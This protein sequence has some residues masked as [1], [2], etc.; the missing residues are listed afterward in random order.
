M[1]HMDLAGFWALIERS[2]QETTGPIE[3]GDWLAA[4]LTGLADE[5][6]IDFQD[7]LDAQTDRVG[8]WLMWHAASLIQGGCSD[9]GFSGFRA[10]LVGLG[11]VVFDR[12]A[13]DPDRLADQPEVQRLAGRHSRTW[14]EEEWP[15][16][17]ELEFVAVHEY[18]RRYGDCASIY[19]AQTSRLTTA[20]PLPQPV[21]EERWDHYDLAES[22]QRLPRLAAMFPQAG[23]SRAT[24]EAAQ[25]SLM[26][27]KEGLE[28]Q[29]AESGRT[30]AE[31]FRGIPP[32]T[33]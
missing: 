23:P 14:A 12:V 27:A 7:H 32:R 13:D 11:P 8:S 9:D 4:A 3:R 5:D 22:R 31:F 20:E 15:Y 21:E 2:A 18:E 29:L 17:E 28:R 33:P 24:P 16:R 26:Q 25:A 6:L 1:R 19:H 10:W 30:L